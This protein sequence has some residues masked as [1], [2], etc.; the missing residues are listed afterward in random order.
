MA[1]ADDFAIAVGSRQ[2][3][4]VASALAPLTA[5]GGNPARAAESIGRDLRS[6]AEANAARGDSQAAARPVR[7]SVGDGRGELRVYPVSDHEIR[8]ITGHLAVT[9]RADTPVPAEVFG[10]P[11]AESGVAHP[12]PPAAEP[13]PADRDASDR[14]GSDGDR[15]DGSESASGAAEFDITSLFDA[16]LAPERTGPAAQRPRLT[17]LSGPS[18]VGKSSVIAELRRLQPDLY[19]SVSATTRRPRPGE[20]DGQSYHFVD[21]AEFERMIAA[22]EL[23][24]HASYAGNFYGT[25]RAPVERAL[26]EGRPVLVEVDVQ[27]ARQVRSTVPDAQLVMLAPPSWDEL[28]TRLTSRGT[29]D[30]ATVN[31]RLETARVELSAQ[32]EYDRVVVNNDVESTAAEL[33]SLVDPQRVYTEVPSIG[34]TVREITAAE[35]G[36]LPAAA[37]LQSRFNGLQKKF[38]AGWVL[39]DDIAYLAPGDHGP[40]NHAQA[41]ADAAVIGAQIRLAVIDDADL[42]TGAQPSGL[43]S[44]GFTLDEHGRVVAEATPL[45]LSN[46]MMG[47]GFGSTFLPALDNLLRRSGV[48][49]VDMRFVPSANRFSQEVAVHGFDWHPTPS[50]M[51]A[52]VRGLHDQAA[53][54]R[55]FCTDA[56]YRRIRAMLDQFDNARTPFDYPTPLQVWNLRG[57]HPQLGRLLMRELAGHGRRTSG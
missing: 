10:A 5:H 48:H 44:A 24:E 14:D 17:A 22:G 45:Y 50:K 42:G 51:A 2:L 36:R 47:K 11:A 54:L 8:A 20:V 39:V 56:D 31:R 33:F 43:I 41:A 28:V 13:T 55:N 32:G 6:A 23:L 1:G 16:L 34:D 57:D 26:A 25:P 37:E 21:R 30:D 35:P 19:Y 40:I 15:P 29:E 7:V 46:T 52:T 18:G 27:G 9:G 4:R 12:E 49:H 38:G 53:L 3:D